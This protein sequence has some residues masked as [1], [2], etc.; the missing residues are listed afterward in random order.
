[1]LT[2]ISGLPDN[3]IGVEAA[4][5][6]TDHD[7]DAVLVPA[8]ESKRA[9]HKQ[10]RML[11]VLGADFDGWSMGALWEDGKLGLSHPRMWEK[12]AFVSDEERVN[13]M[14]KAFGWMVPG[15]VRVSALAALDDAKS[16]VAS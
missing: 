4:G 5:K 10:I 9:A 11:Y 12:V 7:Y 13:H 8:V 1:M 16:W 6:V 2:M 14:I 3:V 15:E